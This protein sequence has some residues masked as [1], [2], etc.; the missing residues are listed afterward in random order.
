MCGCRGL[1]LCLTL[2][3]LILGTVV[4]WA[5]PSLSSLT[6]NWPLAGCNELSL[7]SA[8]HSQVIVA[9][10]ALSL[11]R[12]S[13]AA[14][15]QG[16]L[17]RALHTGKSFCSLWE[18]LRDSPRH[19]STQDP[20]SI[21]GPEETSPEGLWP[22]LPEAPQASSKSLTRSHEDRYPSL[23]QGLKVSQQLVG[24]HQQTDAAGAR[25]CSSQTGFTDG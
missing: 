17:S 16:G 13:G 14:P 22:Q 11:H 12:D 18:T 4:F 20:Q 21:S 24:A 1:F 23:P 7:V 9:A 25:H 6:P 2:L 8:W 19:T 15:A 3:G 10:P 5:G